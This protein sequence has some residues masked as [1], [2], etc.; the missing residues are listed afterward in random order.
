MYETVSLLFLFKKKKGHTVEFQNKVMSTRK[1][2]NSKFDIPKISELT[3]LKKCLF[4][5]TKI[6]SCNVHKVYGIC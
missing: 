2:L 6:Y 1:S 4:L 5:D 3:L